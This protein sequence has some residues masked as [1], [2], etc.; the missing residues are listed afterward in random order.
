MPIDILIEELTGEHVAEVSKL[1]ALCFA[2]PISENILRTLYVGGIA[3][4]FV[5][6]D[7]KNGR[8]AAYGGVVVAAGE[9]QILNIATHPDFR[10]LGIGREVVR[11]IVEYSVQNC[12]E[13]ISLE[14]REG[15]AGAR[16]LYEAEG[17]LEAGRIRNYYNSPKED[18]LIMKKDL[19]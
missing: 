18:A 4:G 12:A 11:K 13:E 8:L 17:F 7:T 6:F 1:E 9:A 15:N 10:R 19:C 16:R 2:S 14:V 3:K 5:C